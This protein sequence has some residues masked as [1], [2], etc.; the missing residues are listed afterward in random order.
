MSWLVILQIMTSLCKNFSNMEVFLSELECKPLSIS[1]T[2][3]WG[4]EKTNKN[5]LIPNEYQILLHAIEQ[6]EVGM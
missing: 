1:L 5:A 4:K 3:T 6:K 2:E